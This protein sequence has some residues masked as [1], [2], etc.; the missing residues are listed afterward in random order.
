MT[1]IVR[2]AFR[3]PTACLTLLSALVQSDCAQTVLMVR[4]SDFFVVDRKDGVP[5]PNHI[6]NKPSPIGSNPHKPKRQERSDKGK[7]QDDVWRVSI[8]ERKLVS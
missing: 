7:Q 8:A 4:K 3:A 1:T 5:P 6:A 2:A